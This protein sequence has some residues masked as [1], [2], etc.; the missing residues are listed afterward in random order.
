MYTVTNW[1]PSARFLFSQDT[2]THVPFDY[3]NRAEVLQ[4]VILSIRKN[5]K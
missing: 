1:S 4:F 5:V 2:R 3:K